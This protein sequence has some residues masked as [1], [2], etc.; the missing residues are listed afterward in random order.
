MAIEVAVPMED[1]LAAMYLIDKL[2]TKNRIRMPLTIAYD[3][4][5]DECGTYHPKEPKDAYKIFVNP[6]QCKSK[7]DVAAQTQSTEPFCPGYCADL[8]LFGVT[9]HEFCHLLQYRSYPKITMEYCK[10]FPTER[11]YLNGYCNNTLQDELAEIMT[12]YITN[13]YLLCLVSKP[14][15]KFCKTFFKSPITCSIERCFFIYDNWPIIVKEHLKNKWKI[16]YDMSQKEF[17]KIND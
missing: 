6:L 2:L 10:N 7:D 17:K 12:L 14:H 9:I 16:V 11:F 4:S 5:I 1:T 8:T 13:P 3:F 15:F